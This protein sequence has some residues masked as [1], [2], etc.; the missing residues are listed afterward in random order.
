MLPEN[1]SQIGFIA[2]TEIVSNNSQY[3]RQFILSNF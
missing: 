1:L 3:Y 2:I